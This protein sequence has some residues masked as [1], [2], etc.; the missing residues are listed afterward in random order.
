MYN[1]FRFFY[2]IWIAIGQPLT[3]FVRWI[4]HD[5][6]G[7]WWPPK[8]IVERDD[9]PLELRPILDRID[10]NPPPLDSQKILVIIPTAGKDADRLQR[11]VSALETA[12]SQVQL[13]TAFIVST[14]DNTVERSL[15]KIISN[16]GCIHK[17]DGAFNY[18]RSINSCFDLHQDEDAILLLNDDCFFQEKGDLD[19]LMQSLN[20]RSL[21]CVGPWVI[22]ERSKRATFH[23]QRPRGFH[24]TL[25]PLVG[26]CVLWSWKWLEK[27]GK[28]DEQFGV[29]Y[30]LD[31]ADQILRAR[32]LGG[33]WGIETRASVLHEEHGTFG[34]NIMRSA[35][36]KKSLEYWNRKYPG[37]PSWGGSEDWYPLIRIS[38]F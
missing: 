25:E 15:E 18:V 21:A 5:L 33:L 11:C 4:R 23:K 24:I 30:G 31:D 22:E 27:I 29:G 10:A 34:K 16:E 9:L 28:F 32:H 6:L 13:H 20:E 17:I 2:R 38:A 12:A 14:C 1:I 36:Y 37:V 3:P 19:V 26:C 35:S 7:A 8:R